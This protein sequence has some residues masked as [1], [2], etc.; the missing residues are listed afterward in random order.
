MNNKRNI[1]LS[2]TNIFSYFIFFSTILL[3]LSIL[4][5]SLLRS[6]YGLDITDESFY[7]NWLANPWIYGGS[8]SQFGF[9]YHPLHLLLHGDISLLRQCNILLIFGLST[10]L[11]FLLLKDGFK[12]TQSQ[13]TQWIQVLPLSLIFATSS[14]IYCSTFH[15]LITPSYNS[16]TLQALLLTSIGILLAE[17]QA[18]PVSVGGWIII[19][20]AG[21]LCFMAKPI[22]AV[23][24]GITVA[25]YIIGTGKFNFRLILISLLSVLVL[26]LLTAFSI[27][28]SVSLFIDRY[29]IGLRNMQLMQL[30][31]PLFKIEEFPL[32]Y[33]GKKLL[34]LNIGIIS[35]L[36]YLIGVNKKL[37]NNLGF[38]ILFVL[39]LAGFSV[40]GG[41]IPINAEVNS[42]ASLQI[43]SILF[44]G[45]LVSGL[46][47]ISSQFI[48]IT[49]NHSI[50]VL[51]FIT[52]PYV[53]AF[54]TSNSYWLQSQLASVFW[55]CAALVVIL[56]AM[57]KS[58]NWKLL[59]PLGVGAQL[60][61]VVT[62]QMAMDHPYRQL[63]PLSQ[64][65]HKVSLGAWDSKLMLS[66]D[67]A[68]FF[69]NTNAL[70]RQSGF[71]PDTPVIDLTG[72]SPGMLYVMGAKPVGQAWIL[73]GYVGSEPLAIAS[74]NT[75]VC[76][77]I[78][79]SWILLE[80]ESIRKIPVDILKNY[81]IDIKNDYNLAAQYVMPLGISG[82]DVSFSRKQLLLKPNRS[83]EDATS[84]CR[85]IERK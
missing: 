8:I 62:L 82:S 9:I 24:L 30:D 29:L 81:G 2:K 76:S 27:D 41:L 51:Y 85:K 68:D 78:A 54:G 33:E 13:H 1:G 50:L 47:I 75:V 56:P 83:I 65:D 63:Q 37:V 35:L 66:K 18:S 17:K 70:I 55:V 11:F 61:T 46:V 43:L 45:I 73:G 80:P 19:G 3:T 71:K 60:I 6:S 36:S 74:L 38:L 49:R 34:A 84:A 20:V 4:S 5:W 10:L 48:T 77:E 69:R 25:V 64:Y 39:I 32:E 23:A 72:E 26:M 44:A 12:N 21:W 28:G 58:P 59:L 31:S 16:L 42:F 67:M 14:L 7:L 40:I 52:L 57:I 15:W 79:A 53:L 22:S